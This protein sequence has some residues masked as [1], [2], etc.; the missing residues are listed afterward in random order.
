MKSYGDDNMRILHCCLA[1]FYIDNYSYQEN[2]LP[3]EHKKKGHDVRIVASTETFLNNYNLGYTKPQTYFNE[4]DILI[5]R[6]PYK[7]FLPHYFMRKIRIYKGIMDLLVKFK[8]DIIFIHNFQFLDIR[9]F[10]KYAKKN[11]HT[12]IIID[13]H[14]DK[15]NSSKTFI[16]RFFLHKILYKYCAKVIEPYT[17]VFWGV[18]PA[19]VDFLYQ[20]YDLPIEKIKLLVM[21]AEDEKVEKARNE[22][23]KKEYRSKL[24]LNENDFVI[25]TG[26]KI[27]DAK[28]QTLLLMKAV[29]E[30]NHDSI[31]L[32]I[33]GSISDK[34]EKEF[35][36][37][38]KCN[39]IKYIG[40]IDANE[41]YF[42]FAIAN[43]VVFPG[44]HSVFWEQV[45]GQGVPMILRYWEG[46]THLDLGGNIEYLY[47]DSS[48]LLKQMI[49]DI[50]ENK[51][52]YFKMK[53][54]AE[55][56]GTSTFSYKEI[57]NKSICFEE[58]NEGEFHQ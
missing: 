39:S 58:K 54:I 57:A 5:S 28:K 45:A 26:G 16:S 12:K 35:Y 9:Q 4:D 48:V 14:T 42:Y 25:V 6:L 18:L 51:E 34:I 38:C 37:L 20:M 2:I 36:E 23:I 40:W 53:E 56:K 44:R 19:R 33:F 11:P 41:S 24:D 8:P 43:L 1:A 55:L 3:R 32:I 17:Y 52:K 22:E 47:E 13:S 46:V 27:D 21:G 30:I 7:K 50:Y 31:K 49:L 29:R 15:H 10:A